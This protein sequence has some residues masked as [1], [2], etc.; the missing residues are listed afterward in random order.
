MTNLRGNFPANYFTKVF[1]F[2]LAEVMW[3]DACSEDR[4]FRPCHHTEVNST[5][6]LM[7]LYFCGYLY[8]YMFLHIDI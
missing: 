1:F 7:L 8:G 4:D 6:C 2:L 3:I 5:L